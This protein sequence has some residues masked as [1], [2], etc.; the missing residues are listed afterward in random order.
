VAERF[1]NSGKFFDLSKSLWLHY[2]DVVK[3]SRSPESVS[4]GPA[5]LL[6]PRLFAAM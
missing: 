6:L 4:V 3:G 2:F 5:F 1:E